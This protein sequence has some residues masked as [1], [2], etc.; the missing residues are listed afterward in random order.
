MAFFVPATDPAQD[1]YSRLT[2][3]NTTLVSSLALQAVPSKPVSSDKPAPPTAAP[4]CASLTPRRAL[5]GGN[6]L[7]DQ[8][9]ALSGDNDRFEVNAGNAG[10]PRQCRCHCAQ[11][12]YN[13]TTDPKPMHG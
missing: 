2:C 4:D 5:A 13:D 7:T 11:S 6:N 1:V 8:P 9:G 10:R 3:P 12:A